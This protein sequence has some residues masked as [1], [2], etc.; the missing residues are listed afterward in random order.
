MV[1]CWCDGRGMVSGAEV[2]NV[3]TSVWVAGCSVGFVAVVWR[4]VDGCGCSVCGMCMVLVVVWA[5][6]GT[7]SL[8]AW[9][10]PSAESS[11]QVSF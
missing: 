3:S 8:A 6:I 4:F 5:V 1:W 10:E 7:C 11:F 9:D 2:F